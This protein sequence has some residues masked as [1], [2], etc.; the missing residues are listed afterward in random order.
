MVENLLTLAI[1]A[2]AHLCLPKTNR[3]FARAHAIELLKLGL[4]D[5]LVRFGEA[6]SDVG[7]KGQGAEGYSVR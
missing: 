6:V 3:V 1:I 2:E 5:I 7:A 4:F